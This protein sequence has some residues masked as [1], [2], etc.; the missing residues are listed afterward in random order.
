[1]LADWLGMDDAAIAAVEDAG[2]VC[3]S[4]SPSPGGEPVEVAR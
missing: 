1:V 4:A 2:G 3:D